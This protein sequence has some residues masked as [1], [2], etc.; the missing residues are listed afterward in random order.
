MEEIK[1]AIMRIPPV[2]RYYIGTV[3][4]LSFAM[5]YSIISPMYLILDFESVFYKIQVSLVVLTDYNPILFDT[6]QLLNSLALIDLEITDN[7]C[8][9]WHFQHEFHLH[10]DATVS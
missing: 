5:T 4:L 1:E 10:N 9:C 8:L 7:L 2:S 6:C 3:F